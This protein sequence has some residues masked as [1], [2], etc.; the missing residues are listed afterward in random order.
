MGIKYDMANDESTP[1]ERKAFPAT[2]SAIKR[3]GAQASISQLID[4]QRVLY[5]LTL[6]AGKAS[7]RASTA[8]AWVSLEEQ[9]RILRNKPLPGSLR[10]TSNANRQRRVARDLKPIELDEQQSGA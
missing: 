7:D 2:P 1:S 5:E 6:D 10:P 4:M 9:K 8:K 3:R